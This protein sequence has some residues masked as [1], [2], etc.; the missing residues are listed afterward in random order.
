M[1]RESKRSHR[2]LKGL[3]IVLTAVT[4]FTFVPTGGAA[5]MTYVHADEKKTE[6][7][8]LNIT[9]LSIGVGETASLY[10]RG[11]KLGDKVTYKSSKKKYATVTSS[12][13]VTAKKKGSTNITVKVTHSGGKS[14]S[15]KCKVTVSAAK[16]ETTPKY[17]EIF[18]KDE[19]T[20][21]LSSGKGGAF[22]LGVP[23]AGI[24]ETIPV[25]GEVILDLNGQ[26]VVK[27][28][29]VNGMFTITDGGRLTIKDSGKTPTTVIN[30]SPKGHVADCVDGKLIIEGGSF[31]SS[32][33]NVFCSFGGDL[34]INGSEI[35]GGSDSNIFVGSGNVTVN[36]GSL[37]GSKDAICISDGDVVVNNGSFKASRYCV[38]AQGG[39]CVINGGDFSLYE[40]K[41]EDPHP[42]IFAVA[43][44]TVSVGGGQ[45]HYDE[46]GMLVN[47][48]RVF[49]NGGEIASDKSTSY[50]VYVKNADGNAEITV[51]GGTLKAG[52]AAML[53]ENITDGGVVINGGTIESTGPVAISAVK[54]PLTITGGKI[55]C[56]NTICS[57]NNEKG[58]V[59]AFTGGS[60]TGGV[61][62]VAAGDA[63]INIEGGTFK[64]SR[65]GLVIGS[66][67]SGEIKYDKNII[68]NVY[69]QRED[70]EKNN[71]KDQANG[72]K[73]FDVKYTKGMQVF[74]FDTLY[75][76]FCIA[77]ENLT[78]EID[79]YTS[80]Q[81]FDAVYL[82]FGDLFRKYSGSC[83]GETTNLK[84]GKTIY[85]DG[86]VEYVIKF[87]FGMESQINSISLN[88]SAY[89]KADKAVREYSDEIDKILGSII[90]ENMTDV[91]KITAVHDYMCDNYEYADPIVED[92]PKSDHSF[93][94]MLDDGTG[95]CQ[96][97]S[98]LFH[99]M[100]LKLGI[101][102]TLVVGKGASDQ[103][104][105]KWESHMW[106]CVTLDGEQFFVD[107]TWDDN[108][109]CKDYF[110]K[111]ATDFYA[112]GL[113]RQ[114]GFWK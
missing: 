70:D 55:K 17:K 59:T 8:K 15:Y 94:A 84:A 9:K 12:G 44:G 21:A 74:D 82:N 11:L 104:A 54:C 91:E 95:V 111:S 50:A 97:Y 72:Y 65:E 32:G 38:R 90:D 25:K 2:F 23:V 13:L 79:I 96:A 41:A 36:G 99:V 109:A 87:D 4:A 107:V 56:E 93:H 60:Y 33:T 28:E 35:S 75:S 51:N 29:T 102:D 49:V 62:I 52:Y 39:T 5:G 45:M 48:G 66:K 110:I 40:K 26:G 114:E 1:G 22:K 46:V 34:V 6:K 100:M 67:Y 101:E 37:S 14:D 71:E 103:W 89:K 81:I 64:T 77:F 83:N 113:H 61:G 58:Q 76:L 63:D 86:R 88:K 31:T 43:G 20:E 10:V 73:R 7:Q 80:P 18:T 42:Y 24:R 105:T 53:L 57:V 19:L 69:D 16:K 27:G 78:D 85:P 108:L 106:N 30:Y 3:A 68:K 98:S 112:D 47:K 92:G